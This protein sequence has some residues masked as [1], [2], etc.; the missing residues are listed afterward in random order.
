[1]N[2]LQFSHIRTFECLSRPYTSKNR[3][4]EYLDYSEDEEDKE[5]GEG[6]HYLHLNH[7]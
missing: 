4:Y 3:G 7:R 1:M 6:N 2:E 5:E